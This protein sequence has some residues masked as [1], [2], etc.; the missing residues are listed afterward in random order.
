MN[1]YPTWFTTTK[2]TPPVGT[3]PVVTPAGATTALWLSIAP[4]PLATFCPAVACFVYSSVTACP[5]VTA[6]TVSVTIPN[7]SS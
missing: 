5:V 1:E 4:P 2:G 7:V 3:T 6:G